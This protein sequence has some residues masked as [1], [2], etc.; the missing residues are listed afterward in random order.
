MVDYEGGGG[1]PDSGENFHDGVEVIDGKIYAI[2]GWFSMTIRSTSNELLRFDP[3]TKQ[4]ENF[5]SYGKLRN[6]PGTAVLNGKLY[7]IDA[8]NS[9]DVQIFDP[10]ANKWSAGPRSPT[11]SD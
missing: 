2:G 4:V 10:K 6:G 9:A 8:S 3:A 11:R 1:H 5:L 7:V